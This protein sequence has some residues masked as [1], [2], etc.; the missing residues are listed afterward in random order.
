[1]NENGERFQGI[2]EVLEKS[3]AI[4]GVFRRSI[5]VG[6]I[7]FRR[8]PVEELNRMLETLKTIHDVLP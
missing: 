3:L 2:G 7:D 5:N 6:N 4:L 8:N 1:M